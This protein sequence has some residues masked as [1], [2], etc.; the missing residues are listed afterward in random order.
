VN[1]ALDPV[2][3]EIARASRA[4]DEGA[5]GVANE[6][7]LRCEQ[8]LSG[9]V[10]P[11][12]A[13]VMTCLAQI[14]QQQARDDD[15][16]RWLD[17]A[18]AIFPTH[19]GAIARRVAFAHA[20]G[21]TATSAALGRRLLA[22]AA[23]D[24]ERFELSA[25]VADD[26]LAAAITAFRAAVALRPHDRRSLERLQAM[27]EAAG[28][29]GDAVNV[30]V[31]MAEAL[32]NA[33]QRARALAHAAELCASR[34]GSV[35]RA[36]ALYEAAIADDPEV[37]GA[38]EAIEKVLLSSGDL[39]GAE[40]ATV[41]QLERLAGRGAAELALLD[42]LAR[43]RERLLDKRG[44][45]QALDRLVVLRP[46]DLEARTRLATLLEA[47]GED[48]LAARCLEA[49]AL[50]A[51]G[52]PRTFRA[53]H[54]IFAKGG[55]MDRAY[56]A[57]G[58]LVHLGEADLDEQMVYQQYAPEVALRPAHALDDAGWELLRPQGHDEAVSAI[59]LAIAPAA[60]AAKVEQLRA[61]R[62][63]PGKLGDKQDTERSTVSAVRA[64]GYVA[65]LL[66]MA[67][68]TVYVR[69]TQ[70]LPG[71]F[72]VVPSP[73]PAVALGPQLLTGRS[74]PELA[75]LLARDLAYVR[76]SG[77]LLAFYP[78]V[79]ELRELVSA[80]IE[81]QLDARL[82]PAQR[83]TLGAAVQVLSARGGTL[84]LLPW[85]RTVERT[86][87]RV[88]L[89]AAGDV[90]VAA[91]LLAVDARGVAGMSAKDRV[92]DLVAFSVSQRYAGLRSALGVAAR[93]SFA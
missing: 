84:D 54:R 21:D 6:A 15:A 36:V 82:D 13:E 66:G 37:P 93:P 7:Y 80:A 85:T 9:E 72:A 62:L 51:P 58:V 17:Q 89:L 11:R 61:K 87:C 32:P 30:A 2:E 25:R 38:F 44:A 40:R 24:A 35:E 26:A 78:T 18:L 92:N 88:G 45:I 55:D 33:G 73:E 81:G 68:P 23:T 57:C 76:L 28:Q 3:D 75:F 19:R 86:A 47:N 67:T 27:H 49:A 48:A 59:V 31:A 90:N 83:R 52:D 12:R 65:R 43:L 64:V 74:L 4:L 8:M 77:R 79:P 5:L 29:F 56:A 22:F 70:D 39:A 41:R 20:S 69:Q 1:P 16:V 60:I 50:H 10:G 91:R 71:G 14:A 34:T 42:K 46:D 63:L 53:L